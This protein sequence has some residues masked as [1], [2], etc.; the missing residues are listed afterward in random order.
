[1]YCTII[2]CTY[3]HQVLSCDWREKSRQLGSVTLNHE[4][5]PVAEIK[6]NQVMFVNHLKPLFYIYLVYPTE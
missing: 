1:M 4:L 5:S 3:V 2:H 6:L